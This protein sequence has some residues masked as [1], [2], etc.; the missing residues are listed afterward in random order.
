MVDESAVLNCNAEIRIQLTELLSPYGI[1][2]A[3]VADSETIPGSFFGDR[4]A[5]L[6]GNQLYLRNNT[7][8]H[9][10][11]HE[12]CHYIC[13]DPIRRTQL[14]TDAEGDYD[15]ENGVCYLQIMLADHIPSM[16]RTR[17]MQDMDNWGYTFRLGSAQAWFEQDAADA[18]QWLQNRN[19]I[20]Q[21][22]QLTGKLCTHLPTTITATNKLV[23]SR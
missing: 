21:D 12:S 14:D 1:N 8:I 18:M 20:C 4:E 23:T 10:A 9:S 3:F 19:I 17:M 15:E 5:G 22:K 13:M 11:L 6:I 2:I 7:P 16:G